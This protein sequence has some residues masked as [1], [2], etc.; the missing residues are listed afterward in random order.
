[1]QPT[2]PSGSAKHN[3]NSHGMPMDQL[4]KAGLLIWIRKDDQD[5]EHPEKCN[6]DF[7]LPLIRLT[8]FIG[9]KG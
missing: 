9:Q 7:P 8:G 6:G 4:T 2:N 1:M 3:V 5:H